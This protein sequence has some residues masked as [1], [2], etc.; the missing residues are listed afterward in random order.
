MAGGKITRI[1]G[2]TNSIECETWTVYTDEFSVYAGQGSHFT[3]DG[4]TNFGEPKEAPS[5]YTYFEKGWW[6]DEEGKEIKEAQLGDKVQFH[7]KMKNIKSPEGKKVNLELREWDEFDFLLYI[8]SL[9]N[10][11]LTGYKNTKG[12]EK[13][14]MVS[15]NP[16]NNE[17]LTDWKMDA[18]S[19]IVISLLLSEDA[20][21]KMMADDEGRDL[22]LYFRCKY[23]DENNFIEV[24]ELPWENWNYLKVKPKQIVEPIIFVHA[25]DKHLLPAIYSVET[26]SPWYVSA[27][28]NGLYANKV[29]TLSKPYG[30]GAKKELTAFEKKAYDIAIRNLEKKNFFS[31]IRK[32]ATSEYYYYDVSDIDNRFEKE[33]KRAV[34]VGTET[35]ANVPKGI[36]AIEYESGKGL[37]GKI[38]IVGEVMGIFGVLSDMAA[39]LR[40]VA[41][42]KIPPPSIIPP[43]VMDTVN[44]MKAENDE[45]I[46]ENWNKELQISIN[47]GRNSVKRA[48]NSPINKNYNL[49]FNFID[50]SEELLTKIL[51]REVYEY[52]K[53]S[54]NFETYLKDQS[55][56]KNEA[57]VLVQSIEENDKYNRL[58]INHYIHA[59]YIKDLKI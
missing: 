14:N 45:F 49:G 43:F 47:E 27:I 19:E 41:D 38:K 30:T 2:G 44:R 5:S 10:K 33:I 58:T 11:E 23:I 7:L 26:G 53:K 56:G 3:A 57:S 28:K 40:G 59:L 13:I 55:H 46:I 48:I 36:N 8:L 54:V 50:I 32:G 16:E 24:A 1:V 20:L 12:Y 35:S 18:N 37:A 6:T 25:S 51:K 4:G 15:T 9:A 31:T 42:H 29:N 22:E 17:A 52:D 21:I 39:L 34:N